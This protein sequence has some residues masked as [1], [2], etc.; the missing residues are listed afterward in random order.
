MSTFIG[1]KQGLE[2]YI[3]KHNLELQGEIQKE[4]F[5]GDFSVQPFIVVEGKIAK[6]HK[7]I[8]NRSTREGKIDRL[9]LP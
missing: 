1:S 6:A 3:K 5:H 4:G 8:T 7:D 9:P 2:S